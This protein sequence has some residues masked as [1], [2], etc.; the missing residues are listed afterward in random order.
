[1]TDL[2]H[3]GNTIAHFRKQLAQMQVTEHPFE[4]WGVVSPSF[5]HGRK[6]SIQGSG[7]PLPEQAGRSERRKPHSRRN[8]AATRNL[9]LN[10]RNLDRNVHPNIA[11]FTRTGQRSWLGTDRHLGRPL[12]QSQN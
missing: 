9:Y 10:T 4:I 6:S 12:V 3:L 5:A 1:I 2:D 7:F 8:P 11:T